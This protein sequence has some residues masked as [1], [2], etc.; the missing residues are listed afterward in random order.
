[1]NN[2]FLFLK[3]NNDVMSNNDDTEICD[4]PTQRPTN[5]ETNHNTETNQHRDQPTQ[6][7]TK[8]FMFCEANSK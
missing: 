5:T 8:S 4:Q 7:P 3:D 6:R 2:Y 1:M